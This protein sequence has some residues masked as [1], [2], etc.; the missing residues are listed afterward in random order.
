M[1]SPS[2][3]AL[4]SRDIV[5]LVLQYLEEENFKETMHQLEQESGLYFN[6]KYFEEEVMNGNWNEVEKYLYG[7]TKVDDNGHSMK[8]FF[9][10]RKQK[11]LEALD[12]LDRAK[13]VEILRKE[14]MV[15]ASSD[16]DLIK[17][18]T[19]LLTLDNFRENVQFSKYGDTESVRAILLVE[20]RKLLEGNP[21]FHGKLQFP[22]PGSSRLRTLIN[23]SL[24]WQHQCCKNPQTHPEVK[25]L[26]VNHSCE[27]PNGAKLLLQA[28]SSL[29]NSIPEINLLGNMLPIPNLPQSCPEAKYNPKDITKTVAMTLDQGFA[30][31]SMDFH[32]IQQTLLLV[33]TN[34]ADIGLWEVA[35]NDRLVLRNF[36]VWDLKKCG[37]TFQKSWAK[38]SKIWINRVIWS[39][40]GPMFGVAYSSHIVQIYTYHGGNDIREH[41]EI[42]AHVGHVHDIVFANLEKR[43]CLI[44]CG[45]DETIKVWD[46]TTGTRLFILRGHVGPVYSI[47]PHYKEDIQFLYSIGCDGKV[48]TWLYDDQGSRKD[49]DA[50]GRWN[51][52]MAYS[53][54]GTRFFFCGTSKNEKFLMEWNE[55]EG[56]VKRTYR[57]LKKCPLGIVKFDTSRNRFLAAGDDYLIKFW[58]MNNVNL[59]DISDAGGGLPAS[60]MIR[61]NKEGSLLAVSTHG[62]GIKI[63]AN[64][65]GLVLLHTVKAC[66]DGL[67]N[68]S[69]AVAKNG[70]NRSIVDAR[71][72][73]AD[74]LMDKSKMREISEAAQC[75]SLRIMDYLQSTKICRL[76]YLNSGAALLALGSNGIHLL[77]K[78]PCNEHNPHGK[79]TASV[80]PQLWVPPTGIFM[81]ND[82]VDS[83]VERGVHCCALTK[84]DSYVVSASGGNISL[85]NMMTSET[86]KKFMHPPPAATFLAFNPQD[87]NVIAIGMEDST[88]LIYNAETH[89]VKRKITGHLNK[90]TGLAFSNV[91]NVLISS[92]ADAQICVWSTTR[93]WKKKNIFLQIKPLST[94]SDTSV[95]LHI[96]QIH[97]LA[98]HKTQIAIYEANELKCV[99]QWELPHESA[100]PITHATFSCDSLLICATFMDATVFIFN[101]SNLEVTCRILPAAYLPSNVNGNVH[102][103]VVTAHPSVSN[104]FAFCLTNGG[105]IVLEPLESEGKWGA[106]AP[107]LEN[108]SVGASSCDRAKK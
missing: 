9:E 28:N 13:A 6:M 96:D 59:L 60:P 64:G 94:N 71:Q 82:V 37:K 12:K 23:Q 84:Y 52:N 48:K 34:I 21:Q 45:D 75:R 98:V 88:I 107:L 22:C 44:T 14:L 33:G 25:T 67:R 20:L 53:A 43:L 36:K 19:L 11:F 61:F 65:D 69:E 93:K 26:F 90:I 5:Y 108:G 3:K 66:F 103:V 92:G 54:D 79:A 101:S 16:A 86:I 24:N 85:F 2:Q 62:N 46:A 105:I 41:L 70:D 17:D 50:P 87:H 57:G 77:W 56:S 81:I 8:I 83:N 42:D 55:S 27:Q 97:F 72:R 63:L 78:W 106:A 58:D 89:E 104:Q 47:C 99:N 1:S 102:P 95:Q 80:S 30:I 10:I 91:L 49:Y 32:P 74:D 7:F 18:I 68:P 100:A 40:D 15:F 4:L 39:L 29:L 31:N 35:T 76:M 73:I 38:N 51:T